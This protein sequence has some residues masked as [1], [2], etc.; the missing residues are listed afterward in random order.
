M[1]YHL[2]SCVGFQVI[3]ESF[4]NNIP[5]KVKFNGD[6]CIARLLSVLEQDTKR[7]VQSIGTRG[8]FYTT[9]FKTLKRDFGDKFLSSHLKLK[10]L[11]DQPQ[12][13]GNDRITLHQYHEPLRT[14]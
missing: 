14:F 11:F 3:V 13:K 6:I 4:C 7:S 8:I 9:V 10:N 2:L 5:L 12:I 1:F